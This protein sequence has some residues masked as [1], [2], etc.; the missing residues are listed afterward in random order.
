[1]SRQSRV[2]HVSQTYYSYGELSAD[3]YGSSF[4]F[5]CAEDE[6][7]F[8]R[9]YREVSPTPSTID[10]GWFT[11]RNPVLLVTNTTDVKCPLLT[12]GEDVRDNYDQSILLLEIDGLVLRVRPKQTQYL[13]LAQEP[14][15][16]TFRSAGKLISAVL[17]LLPR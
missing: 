5:W 17:Q 12:D 8:E 1:M 4:A 15:K 2:T 10:L 11:G 9:I 6:Q 7:A 13:E 3:S 14:S 16:I